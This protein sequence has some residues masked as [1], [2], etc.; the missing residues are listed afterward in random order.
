MMFAGFGECQRGIGARSRAEDGMRCQYNTES[1]CANVKNDVE[2][3]LLTDGID[4]SQ[5]GSGKHFRMDMT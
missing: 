5:M 4:G 1:G 2:C 3:D